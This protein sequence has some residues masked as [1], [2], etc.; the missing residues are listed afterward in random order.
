MEP[1]IIDR[2]ALV[3]QGDYTIDS[4]RLSVHLFA[5][6]RNKFYD[7]AIRVVTVIFLKIDG[8]ID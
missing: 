7:T 3:K 1:F 5:L 4:V 2:V 8:W 6:S